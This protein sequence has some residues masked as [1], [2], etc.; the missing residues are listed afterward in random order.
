MAILQF[1]K[2]VI[3]KFTGRKKEGNK[4]LRSVDSER[5]DT[6]TLSHDI[7]VFASMLFNNG[8][9][10]FA[11]LMLQEASKLHIFLS[12]Y[13][14]PVLV[15][16]GKILETDPI[17]DVENSVG[18]S[19]Y[20]EEL[21]EL[22]EF[23]PILKEEGL[24]AAANV[25]DDGW[26]VRKHSNTAM[27]N[28]V[29]SPEGSLATL[30]LF[31]YGKIRHAI[32]HEIMP[33][34]CKFFKSLFP[35]PTKFKLGMIK[36]TSLSPKTKTAPLDGLT[37]MRLRLLIPLQIPTGFQMLI[38]KDTLVPMDRIAVIDDSFEHTYMNENSSEPAVWL[39]VDLQH[40]DLT[41][42]EVKQMSVTAYA[43]QAFISV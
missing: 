4:L 3:L 15:L 25:T 14:R 1:Y 31:S 19:T 5:F 24:K 34:T 33:K 39:S 10:A 7:N 29:M 27:G 18:L 20:D 13:Q 40:P 22:K 11:R 16:P 41:P 21:S 26:V 32:C 43:K 38:A 23:L 42:E 36:L 12:Q 28:I 2:G 9:E 8:D 17:W 35:R 6:I 37:N 30:P